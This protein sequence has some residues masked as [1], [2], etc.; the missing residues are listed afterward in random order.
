MR[1][2]KT[3]RCGIGKFRRGAGRPFQR[4]ALPG[5]QPQLLGQRPIAERLLAAGYGD[6][7]C[8]RHPLG[9]PTDIFAASLKVS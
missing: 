9:E 2:S 8:M 6:N 4:A 1:K 3:I 7:L 5:K